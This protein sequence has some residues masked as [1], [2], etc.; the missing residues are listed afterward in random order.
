VAQVLE[1]LPSKCEDLSSD[2]QK[3]KDRV[4]TDYLEG[5]RREK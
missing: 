1:C 5:I 3:R 4:K 2:Q